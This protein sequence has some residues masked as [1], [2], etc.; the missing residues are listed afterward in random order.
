M[1][2]MMMIAMMTGKLPAREECEKIL[3]EQGCD[4]S[5]IAHC[6]MVER[7]AKVIADRLV[8]RGHQI[9]SQLISV[10]ALVHD[11][12]RGRTHGIDHAV[13]GAAI[14]K[15]KGW[16]PRLVRLIE[17]HIGAGLPANEAAALGLPIK[18]FI[19]LTLEEKV[20]AQ[21]DNLVSHDRRYPVRHTIMTLESMGLFDGAK[22]IKELH[23][24]LSDMCGVDLDDLP[25]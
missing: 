3:K 7:V 23:K 13:Q 24:E 21:A 22:R 11:I 18:D 8:E 9:D 17:V 25:I 12:G 20:V 15:E 5:V 19:P 16:D 1:V 2:R 14:A 10:G 6:K 4:G